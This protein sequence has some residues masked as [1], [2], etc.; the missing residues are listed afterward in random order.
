LL[1]NSGGIAQL[2]P[3]TVAELAAHDKLD[4]AWMALRGKV[5]NITEYIKYH[6]GGVSELMRGV[7]R[8]ATDLYS[9][10][11]NIDLEWLARLFGLNILSLTAS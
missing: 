6:P 2:R 9:I 8:D 11:T 1:T 4:D 5:Y 3:V 10:R 7:G